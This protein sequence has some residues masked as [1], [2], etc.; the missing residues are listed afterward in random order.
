MQ[1]QETGPWS[2]GGRLWRDGGRKI[3]ARQEQVYMYFFYFFLWVD[4]EG[5]GG[6]NKVERLRS[7]QNANQ[8]D[9]DF[10]EVKMGVYL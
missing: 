10:G 2:I 1:L 7:Y 5:E 3:L 8:L 9:H 6:A 4:G